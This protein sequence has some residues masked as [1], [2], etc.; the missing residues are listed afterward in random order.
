MWLALALLGLFYAATEGVLMALGSALLP[1]HLRASG[2]ALLTTG[3]AVAR[4]VGS[5]GFGLS[6]SRFGLER[7]LAAFLVGLI[8]AIA[9][10]AVTTAAPDPDMTRSRMAWMMVI[11]LTA[12]LAAVL[13]WCARFEVRG[14]ANISSQGWSSMTKGSR[15]CCGSRTRCSEAPGSVK[16]TVMSSPRRCAGGVR[17]Q[18]A[19]EC[20]RV[21]AVAGAGV[22][23]TAERGVLTKYWAITFDRSAAAAPKGRAVGH[24]EPRPAVTRR[25]PRRNHRIRQRSCL[26][27]R[28]VLDPHDA[29]GR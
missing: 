21:D 22:C 15:N 23:L 2:L 27:E 12:T 13:Y 28:S 10:V 4:F 17:V 26:L 14:S 3:L 20:D 8:I 24:P 5:V 25:S 19:L 9:A 1:E 18:S 7:T 29:V 16:G 11:T 6:W